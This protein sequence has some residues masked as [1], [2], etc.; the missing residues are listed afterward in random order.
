MS[1]RRSISRTE[2]VRIFE[3][4]QGICHICGEAIDGT[5]DRWDVEHVV[6]LNLGGDDHGDNL[7]PAHERCHK[8]KSKDDARNLAKAKS[9][10]SKHIGARPNP[11]RPIPGSRNHHLKRKIGGGVEPRW[12]D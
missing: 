2:R 4:A 6:P 9:V 1:R 8:G 3:A 10:H 11:T 12:K 7:Q 5:R